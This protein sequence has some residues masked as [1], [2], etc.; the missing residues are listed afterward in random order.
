MELKL[1][2]SDFC[3]KRNNIDA[4]T[5]AFLSLAS[6]GTQLDPNGNPIF[7][8]IDNALF[9]ST[10]SNIKSTNLGY[11]YSQYT[12]DDLKLLFNVWFYNIY[13]EAGDAVELIHL[14]PDETIDEFNED[15]ILFSTLAPYVESGSYLLFSRVDYERSLSRIHDNFVMFKFNL[16][17]FVVQ[18]CDALIWN[19]VNAGSQY[20]CFANIK[21]VSKVNGNVPF[22]VMPI[23]GFT[24][25]PPVVNSKPKKYGGHCKKCKLYDDYAEQDDQ[26]E[27]ICYNCV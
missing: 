24:I 1:I 26:G 21:P 18:N 11:F 20:N 6:F 3:I 27:V 13:E 23:K 25:T 15:P 22:T 8:D 17:S 19:T 9:Q 7:Q 4:A 2:S 5:T 16:G 10:C 14:Y 12:F